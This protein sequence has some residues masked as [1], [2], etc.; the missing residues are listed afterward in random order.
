M[1]MVNVED[2]GRIHLREKKVQKCSA[3]AFSMLN[4]QQAFNVVIIETKILVGGF[5][6][7]DN[8]F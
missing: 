5:I 7:L 4:V 1:Q 2:L 3:T 8:R 6:S